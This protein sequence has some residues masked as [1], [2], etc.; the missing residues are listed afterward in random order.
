[1]VRRTYSHRL[2]EVFLLDS[3]KLWHPTLR[4]IHATLDD[5]PGWISSR[6]R[7]PSAMP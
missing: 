7:W 4:Q 3:H 6:R 2:V 5:A 1:M